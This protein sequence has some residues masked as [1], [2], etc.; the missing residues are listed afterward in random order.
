MVIR[1]LMKMTRKATQ[2]SPTNTGI[3]GKA[4]ANSLQTKNKSSSK[5]LEFS[6]LWRHRK[7]I[8]DVR[9]PNFAVTLTFPMSAFVTY[10]SNKRIND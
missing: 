3:K 7:R 9:I 2:D 5:S 6:S 8:S 10:T 1:G 4:L